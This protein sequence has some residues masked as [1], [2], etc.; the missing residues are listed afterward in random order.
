[1]NSATGVTI[2]KLKLQIFQNKCWPDPS[3]P[4]LLPHFYSALSAK[5]RF[6]VTKC[7]AYSVAKEVKIIL[8]RTVFHEGKPLIL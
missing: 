2:R 7:A 8:Y 3:L 6:Q 4:F 1:M 5:N